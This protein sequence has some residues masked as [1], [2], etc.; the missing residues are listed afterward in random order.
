MGVVL[1]EA[2]ELGD[3]FVVYGAHT[4]RAGSRARSFRAGSFCLYDYRSCP[5]LKSCRP[6][7]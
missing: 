3:L 6:L 7:R 1:R 2:G 5:H 4:K